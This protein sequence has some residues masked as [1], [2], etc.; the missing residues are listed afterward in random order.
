MSSRYWWGSSTTPARSLWG[1]VSSFVLHITIVFWCH[2]LYDHLSNRRECCFYS[3]KWTTDEIFPA[4]MGQV[5]TVCVY[6]WWLCGW[7]SQHTSAALTINENFDQGMV[8]L[9]LA[10]NAMRTQ[11]I[12]RWYSTTLTLDVCVIVSDVRTGTQLFASEYRHPQSSQDYLDMDMALD[13]VVP[14]DLNWRHTDEGPE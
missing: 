1:H 12:A 14:E 13:N 2:C 6:W 11:L 4:L 7:N 8:E 10:K 5:I 3:C 9:I